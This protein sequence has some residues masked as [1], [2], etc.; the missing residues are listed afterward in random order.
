MVRAIVAGLFIAV[1]AM[2][3]SAMLNLPRASQHARIT[4]RIGITDITI[5]Y[6][7]PQVRG[8]KIF[9]KVEAYGQVWRAGANENTVI[10]FTDP[11]TIEGQ[12]LGKGMYG[13]HMLPGEATWVVIFSKNHTSWGS[14]TYDQAEDALRVAVQPEAAEN[15]ESLSYDFDDPKPDSAVITMRW[16]KVAVRFKVGVNTPEVVEASLRNQL[17]GRIQFE[18]QPWME[19]ANYLLDNKLSAEEAV[20]DADNAIANEDRFEC[21][22]T[23]ARALNTLGR[24]E[25]AQATYE[26]AL[27]MGNQQQI[28]SFARV[29]QG[30]GRGDE[31]LKLF[32]GNIKKDPNSWVARNEAARIA[33]AQGDYDTAL[34]E[35]KQ[36]LARAPDA[37]KSQVNDLVQR[38]ERRVDINK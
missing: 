11:V 19:A 4:Q 14:F 31:A 32:E 38:L 22:I 34:R 35:M 37:I 29:L 3:Q 18:W 5:D 30:Q 17:R 36:A 1:G 6:S 13:L 20:K 27:A 9:G 33:V 23:K 24:K 21:E 28:H 8:R 26:K 15:Q 2:A 16:E 7:R 12:A 25:E 10:E